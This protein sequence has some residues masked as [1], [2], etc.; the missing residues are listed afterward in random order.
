MGPLCTQGLGSVFCMLICCGLEWSFSNGYSTFSSSA[1]GAPTLPAPLCMCIQL[2]KAVVA[3]ICY[4]TTFFVWLWM[5]LLCMS[6]RFVYYMFAVLSINRILV[7]PIKNSTRLKGENLLLPRR[8]PFL[9]T[10]DLKII[11]A[12]L[13]LYITKKHADGEWALP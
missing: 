11:D 9:K 3:P 7:L 6:F 12:I 5:K 4:M 10:G 2:W 8:S 13:A 1:L